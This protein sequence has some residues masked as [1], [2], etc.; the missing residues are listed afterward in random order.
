MNTTKST[1][2]VEPEARV[3]IAEG[4]LWEPATEAL[5][6]SFAGRPLKTIEF[7]ALVLTTPFT[8]LSTRLEETAPEWEEFP[9]GVE[10]A[11]VPAQPVDGD[12]PPLT[13]LSGSIRSVSSILNRYYVDLHGSFSDYLEKFNS[14]ERHNLLRRVK[15]FAE[16]SGGETDK[17]E[18]HSPE[19][20]RE[21]Y[22]FAAGVSKNSWHEQNGGRSFEATFPLEKTLAEA[23]HG[24]ARGYMLFHNRQPVAYIF[25]RANREHIVHTHTAYDESY[26]SHA[27]GIV[28][29]YLML[30]SLYAE[31]KYSFLDF[32]HGV[33]A[34]KDLLS[35]HHIPCV[36]VRYFKRT[37]RNTLIV[38]TDYMLIALS[39]RG[40]RLLHNLGIKRAFK[41]LF[42]GATAR[43]GQV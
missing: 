34:Y 14:K 19:G 7:A 35:T 1:A 16:F 27:P 13:F 43:P 30:E 41:K 8:R 9:A 40:G 11:V 6:V 28:L 29:N 21:F 18:F 37:A 26:K 3:K 36:T 10:V 38:T 42:M 24:D 15:K 23:A 12:P 5:Y 25:C 31:G 2:G 39:T 4:V 33:L 20:M 17:R 22:R 32:G